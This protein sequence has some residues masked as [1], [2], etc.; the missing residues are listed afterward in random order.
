[1]KK[2]SSRARAQSTPPVRHQL[3]HVVP[4]V[5]HDPEEEMTALG[6]LA[7]HAMLEPRRY[8]G[9]PAV[10]IGGLLLALIVSKLMGGGT[11]NQSDVWSKLELARTPAERV[12]IAKANPKS[13]A[14]TW[15]LLQAAT[16]YFSES[17]TD[18]PNNHDVALETSKK[19]LDLFDQVMREAPHDSPQARIAAL[20]RARTL[21]MRNELSKAIEQYQLVSKDWPGTSEAEDAK[22]YAEALKDPQAAAFYKELYAYSPAKVTLPPFGTETFPPSGLG[23]GF[24]PA[25]HPP[26][27][28]A[29]T[30]SAPCRRCRA[31]WRFPACEADRAQDRHSGSPDAR[32]EVQP[33]PAA[34]P[35][36]PSAH[37]EERCHCGRQA[38]PNPPVTSPRTPGRDASR[39]S[40]HSRRVE[41]TPLNRRRRT[42]PEAPKWKAAHEDRE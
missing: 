37:A 6:R 2:Q 36:E 40:L 17:L 28:A 32:H 15:A 31:T 20:G 19:A 42:K 27:P 8:L 9:W 23:S 12:D 10:I 35:A 41:G 25:A 39:S 34:K 21:E 13:P 29:K 5:I 18:L 11:S 26:S 4:T 14:A 16:G 30:S 3:E 22:R 7:H 33:A 1:M 38:R 24:P